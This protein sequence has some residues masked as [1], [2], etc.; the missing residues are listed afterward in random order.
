LKITGIYHYTDKSGE[1]EDESGNPITIVSKAKHPFVLYTD[2]FY[3][4]DGV[5]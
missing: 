3:A 1:I 2:S 5:T 4:H